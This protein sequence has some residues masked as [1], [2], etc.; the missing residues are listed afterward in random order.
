MWASAVRSVGCGGFGCLETGDFT[1]GR[2]KNPRL[3][4][5]CVDRHDDSLRGA[6]VD[7]NPLIII[8][9]SAPKVFILLPCS[10]NLERDGVLYPF[11]EGGRSNTRIASSVSGYRDYHDETAC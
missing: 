2:C 6:L 10:K 5:H 4:T 9:P 3:H 8:N 1:I 11:L 7:Q